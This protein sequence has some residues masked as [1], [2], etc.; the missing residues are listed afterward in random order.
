M[1]NETVAAAVTAMRKMLDDR[2]L[3]GTTVEIAPGAIPQT[4]WA[5]HRGD[6]LTLVVDS[7]NKG[8]AVSIVQACLWGASPPGDTTPETPAYK[9]AIVV[10]MGK[11]TTQSIAPLKECA[12]VD[13]EVFRGDEMIQNITTVA[14]C[15]HY[16]LHRG[17]DARKV[18]PSSAR[19]T[20][21]RISL[22]SPV[23]RYYGAKAG[24]VFTFVSHFP[25]LPPEERLRLVYEPSLENDN[26][27]E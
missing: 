1:E 12:G 27:A 23:S 19:S 18:L 20:A 9:H 5:G 21:A 24:N 13:V 10:H 22:D 8:T 6:Y 11:A 15:P 17:E 7:L 26:D 2:H 16:T 25:P 14:M 3:S 4:L